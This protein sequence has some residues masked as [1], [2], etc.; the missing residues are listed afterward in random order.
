MSTLQLTGCNTPAR[1]FRERLTLFVDTPSGLRLGSSVVDYELTFQDGWWGGLAGHMLLPGLRGEAVAVELGQYGVLFALLNNDKTRPR[2]EKRG[3]IAWAAFPELER[4][5]QAD[6][7][8]DSTNSLAYFIDALNRLKPTG[9]VETDALPQVVRFRDP[10][11]PKTV[12][13]V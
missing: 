6:A 11:D 12:E 4:Q 2:S 3:G 8:G 10:D 5:A 13:P 1:R 9:D 7:R